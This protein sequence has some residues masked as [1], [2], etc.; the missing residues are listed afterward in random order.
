MGVC[1]ASAGRVGVGVCVASDFASGA[2]GEGDCFLEGRAAY[3]GFYP[4]VQF[5]FYPR[6]GFVVLRRLSLSRRAS[7][8]RGF[9]L[10]F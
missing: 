4:Y 3:L 8:R 10:F 7:P 6:P 9:Y 5:F 1:V 2:A